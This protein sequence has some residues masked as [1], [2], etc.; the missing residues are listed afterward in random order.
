L[1][2]FVGVF[3]KVLELIALGAERFRRQLRG[4]FDSRNRGIFRHVTNFVD[5]DTGFPGQ[6]GL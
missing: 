5:L 2:H 1:Q 6:R 3:E 4:H